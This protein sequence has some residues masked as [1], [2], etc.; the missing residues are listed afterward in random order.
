MVV[1][2]IYL[3]A[4]LFICLSHEMHIGPA[5]VW[6]PPDVSSLMKNCTPVKFMLMAA[7]H[8]WRPQTCYTCL[9]YP[10]ASKQ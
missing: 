1:T 7:A 5:A 2:S 4:C 8:F 10:T 6:L 9:I 3:S